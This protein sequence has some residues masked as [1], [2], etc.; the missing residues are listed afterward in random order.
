MERWRKPVIPTTV[1]YDDGHAVHL[2]GVVRQDVKLI[3]C[4]EDV[5]RIRQGY[6]CMKCL[7]PHPFAF[8]Q[9]CSVCGYAMDN[10][11]RSDFATHYGGIERIGPSTSVEDEIAA[12]RER[13][14]AK[15]G[16][17]IWIPDSVA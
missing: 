8:P 14:T 7:E 17:Q 2:D 6:V 9:K 11:Q 15:K 3:L 13:K 12:M 16:S 4:D 10:R 1:E 5:E